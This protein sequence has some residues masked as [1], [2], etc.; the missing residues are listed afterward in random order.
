MIHMVSTK[1]DPNMGRS[2]PFTIS[3]ERKSPLT[4]GGNIASRHLKTPFMHRH[5]PNLAFSHCI[6]EICSSVNTINLFDFQST[7]TYWAF[8]SPVS[9]IH[10]GQDYRDIVYYSHVA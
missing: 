6:I 1:L 2:I 8:D 3:S 7:K 10:D 9:D 5:H 4:T